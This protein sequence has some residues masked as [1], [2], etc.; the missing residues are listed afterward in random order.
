M[1]ENYGETVQDRQIPNP[2]RTFGEAYADFRKSHSY[3]HVKVIPR[4]TREWQIFDLYKFTV[5]VYMYVCC[6]TYISFFRAYYV[7]YNLNVC[8]I[9]VLQLKSWQK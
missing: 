9:V 6:Q 7:S 3:M 8:T 4:E 5:C 1:V 2:V